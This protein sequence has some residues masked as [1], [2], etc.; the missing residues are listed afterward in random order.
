MAALNSLHSLD[1][2]CIWYPVTISFCLLQLIY[3]PLEP[4][5]RRGGAVDRAD[6]RTVTPP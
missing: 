3:L 1:F 6:L 2:L 4:A 5:G